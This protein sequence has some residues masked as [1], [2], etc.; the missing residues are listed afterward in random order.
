MIEGDTPGEETGGG[1]YAVPVAHA[2][3][4][5][6]WEKKNRPAMAPFIPLKT[7]E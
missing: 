3:L 2:I 1:R 4:K 7:P 6:W 5:T